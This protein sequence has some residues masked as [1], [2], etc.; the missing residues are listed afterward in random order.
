[1]SIEKSVEIGNIKLAF[2]IGHEG[3][4]DKRILT[5]IR[6]TVGGP[7]DCKNI[8]YGFSFLGLCICLIIFNIPQ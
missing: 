5:K 4:E 8:V 6:Y 1:M 3:F 7:F 2:I